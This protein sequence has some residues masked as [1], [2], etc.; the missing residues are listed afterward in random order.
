M[1]KKVYN[2]PEVQVYALIPMQVICNVSPTGDAGI[3]GGLGDIPDPPAV[4]PIVGD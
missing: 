3:G 2:N 1:K 4:G